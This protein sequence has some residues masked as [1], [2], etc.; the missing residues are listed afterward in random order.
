M[1]H[2]LNPEAMRAKSVAAAYLCK[3]LISTIAYCE[4]AAPIQQQQPQVSQALPSVK[5]AVEAS[6]YLSKAD[7]VEI[8]SLSSPPQPVTIVCVSICILLGKDDNSGWA[9]AKAMVSDACFL[10]T[11]LEH[12]KEDVTAEQI[13]KV[14]Q[15]LNQ[16]NLDINKMK[17]ISKAAYGLLQWV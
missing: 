16:E 5:A 8:K 17:S 3:W 2:V 9:G 13:E 7:I 15:L 1:G 11:L 6:K 10:K 12:K 4:H 14:H